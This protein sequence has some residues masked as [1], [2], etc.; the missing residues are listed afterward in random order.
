M[1]VELKTFTFSSVAW[2]LCMDN[3]V[4]GKIKK[5]LLFT[6]LENTD[7]LGSMNSNPYNIRH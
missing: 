5:R 6:M 2:S 7:F 1:R 3:A 4:L